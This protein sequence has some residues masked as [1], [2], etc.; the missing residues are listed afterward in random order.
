MRVSHMPHV[1][2]DEPT[3]ERL[4]EE[5]MIVSPTYVGMNHKI[6]RSVLNM[7][8]KPH[9]SGDEPWIKTRKGAGVS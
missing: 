5:Y 2:G 3:A 1:S 6:E 9:A 8:S 7:R 4:I